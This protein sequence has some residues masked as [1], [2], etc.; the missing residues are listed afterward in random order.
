MERVEVLKDILLEAGELESFFGGVVPVDL[1]RAKKTKD[2]GPLFALVEEETVRPRGAPRKPDITIEDGWVRVRSRP[3]GI[4][5]FD[6]PGI[7]KGSWG[8]YKIPA[9]TLLPVGL[10][11]VRD[12]FNPIFGATHHTIAPAHDMPLIRFKFLLQELAAMLEQE[13]SAYGNT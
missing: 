8:Y 2:L 1:W 6:R 5:T 9:G 10:V 4:S 12:R 13:D 11:I 3:R 7:F